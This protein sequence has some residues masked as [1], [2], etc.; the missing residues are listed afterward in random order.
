MHRAGFDTGGLGGAMEGQGLGDGAGHRFFD[1]D[2]LAGGD[3]AQCGVDAQAG[4]GGVE[5]QCFGV[6]GEGGVEV[7]G[8]AVKA[9]F[10]RCGGEFGGVSADQHD[11]W[12]QAGA[13][14]Q[15]EAA[16][17]AHGH[18]GGQVLA[19]REFAGGAVENDANA[20]G[21]H[22]FRFTCTT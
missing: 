21:C 16:F 8:G 7:G 9:G 2:V 3:G 10:C 19:G 17:V 4:G 20:L 18:Q 5:E 12:D 13:I 22:D 11:V 1:V 15:A 6:R 14:G